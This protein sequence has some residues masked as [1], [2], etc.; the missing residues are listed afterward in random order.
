MNA[1]SR[2]EFDAKLEAIEARMDA[3]IASI[4]AKV[5]YFMARIDEKFGWMDARMTNI[6][7]SLSEMKK[8][9]AGM[10][11]T[12]I[13]TAVSASLAIVLGVATFNATLLANMLASFE[14]GK[15]TTLAQ[16]EIRKQAEETAQ[17]LKQMQRQLDTISKK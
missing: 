7:T 12:I 14:S 11:T 8:S 1:P 16:A 10:K 15:N 2:E 4:E 9:I 6:E 17:L 5:D 13:V 3:R